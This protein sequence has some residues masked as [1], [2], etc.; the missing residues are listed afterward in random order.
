MLTILVFGAMLGAGGGA[1]VA[2]MH[3]MPQIRSLE[4]FNPSRVTRIYASDKTVLAEFFVEKRVPVSLDII[5]NYLKS[6]IISTEDS[7]FYEHTGVDIKGIMRAL[8]KDIMAR[9]F[10]EGASTITQ[11]LAKTLF[12]T[13]RKS[14]LRK[15]K[16]ALLAIQIERRYTKDEILELYLNQIYLGSGAYGVEAAANIYFGKSVQNLTLPECALIAGLPKSPSRYSPFVNRDLALKRRAVVLDRMKWTDVISEKEAEQAKDAPLILAEAKKEV[17]RAPYFVAY[18]KTFLEDVLGQEALYRK[19]LTVYTTLDPVKQSL[20]EKVLK[21]DLEHLDRETNRGGIEGKKYPQGALVCL[22]AHQGSI[23]A[24]IGG[25]DFDKSSFNRA[26][27][28]L[29]QP[30]SAFKPIVYAYA[31]EQ[32]FNQNDTIWDGPIMFE[33]G[34]GEENWEPINFSNDY[35]GEMSLRWALAVSENIPA[36]KLLNK[37]GVESVVQF[38]HNMGITSVLRPNLTLAL[39]ASE[40]TLLEL[41]AAYAVFPNQGIWI[42]PCG[43]I[44][45][46]DNDGRSLWRMRTQRRT[47]I[48]RETAYIMTDMMQGVIQNGTGK[49]AKKIGRPLGGKTGT[50]DTCRDALFVGFSP[51]LVTGVWVGCDNHE[52]LGDHATGG[53]IALPIWIDFMGG[54]MTGEPYQD[55]AVPQN[56]IRVSIDRESGL[57]ASKNCPFAEEAAFIKGTEPT[58]YCRH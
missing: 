42:K 24:M 54:A 26:T 44:E 17:W 40:V 22:D 12:L 33:G 21:T 48:R 28:A 51:S 34:G 19:G 58:M 11:Q 1:Y 4:K 20:A 8:F 47:V 7:H 43:V 13:P 49:K 45:V 29:R 39:G 50:T 10:I 5:P 56:I 27:Q 41:T 46:F 15:I 52:S 32:G 23:L 38:A 55:F 18:I 6:A 14:I 30:G 36:V 37:L 31:I 57:L 2:L 25:R 35:K 53:R 3:D 9:R 16:E